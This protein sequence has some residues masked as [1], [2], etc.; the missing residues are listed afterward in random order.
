MKII[1][2]IIIMIIII[3]IV[4]TT[5]MII[6]MII[7]IIIMDRKTRK[8]MAICGMLHPWADVDRLYLPRRYGG[9]EL[10][11]GEDYVRA[12]EI[13]LSSYVQKIEEPL[14][15]AVRNKRSPSSEKD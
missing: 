11:G 15:V 14:L 6:I 1:I 3:I 5:I 13:G 7:M 10:I 4:I 9:R 12:E 8:R 2:T